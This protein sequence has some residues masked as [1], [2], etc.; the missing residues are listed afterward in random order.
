MFKDPVTLH[1]GHSYCRACAV[2]WFTAP[3]KLCPAGRCAASANCNPAALP[4]AFAL[5]DVVESQRVHCRNGL[6]QTASGLA[7]DAHGC[8]ERP[9]LADAA[10]HET[11]CEHAW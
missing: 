4:T 11:V 6:Y 7:I 2:R 5:R 3:T 1:C 10:A 9:R 8:I